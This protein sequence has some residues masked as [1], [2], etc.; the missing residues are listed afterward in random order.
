MKKL[1]AVVTTVMTA[2][3]IVTIAVAIG[4]MN[5]VEMELSVAKTN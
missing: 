4:T 5:V 2:G 3:V 1:C